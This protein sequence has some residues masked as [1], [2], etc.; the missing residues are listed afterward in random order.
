N[1]QD[2]YKEVLEVFHVSILSMKLKTLFLYNR[3]IKISLCFSTSRLSQ[4]HQAFCNSPL[5]KTDLKVSVKNN[6]IKYIL[7][8]EIP[9]GGQS[10]V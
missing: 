10:G 6:L 8:H 3:P 4:A 1:N 9:I 7:I 2:K 5:N